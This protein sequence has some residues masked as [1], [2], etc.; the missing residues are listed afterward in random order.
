VK[1]FLMQNAPSSFTTD[2]V[3]TRGFGD[4]Q[5]IADNN[6]AAGKAKNRRVEVI[7]RK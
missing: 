2:R 4:T 3:Q 7:L 6:F 1:N 5:P